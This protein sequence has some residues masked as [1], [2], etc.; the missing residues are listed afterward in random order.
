ME[1]IYRFNAQRK[2]FV[3]L[4]VDEHLKLTQDVIMW[5]QYCE[6][7]KDMM[8]TE[9]GHACNWCGKSENEISIKQ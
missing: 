1:Y 3:K 2:E 7:E 8:G 5:D 9:K 6:L 4:T